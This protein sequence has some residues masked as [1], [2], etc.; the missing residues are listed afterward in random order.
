MKQTISVREMT[1]SGLLIILLILKHVAATGSESPMNISTSEP[2]GAANR[3]REVMQSFET[4]ASQ[5]AGVSTAGPQAQAETQSR[6]LVLAKARRA[7]LRELIVTDPE[8]ALSTSLPPRLRQGFPGEIENEMET[9]V[10]GTGDLFVVGVLQKKDGPIVPPI[11]RFVRINGK[12][13]QAY[14][15]GKLL[16]QKTTKNIPIHGIALDSLLALDGQSAGATA[17]S[18]PSVTPAK[19][20]VLILRVDFPD[21]PGDPGNG[22]YTASYVQNIMDSQIAPFFQRSSYGA[23]SLAYTV[24][25][26]VYRLPQTASFYATRDIGYELI[27]DAQCA[28]NSDFP[29]GNYDSFVVLFSSLSDLPGSYIT[30]GGASEIGGRNIWINGEFDFRVLVHELGHSY[31]LWHANLWQVTD[32]NPISSSGYGVEYADLFDAMSANLANDSR[33][34]YN[35]WFKSQVGWI[36]DDQIQVVSSSGTYRVHPFDRATA[37]GTLALKIAKDHLRNYWIGC[38]HNFTNNASMQNGA[39]IIWGYNVSQGSDLLDTTTPG[40]NVQD[41]A[42]AI[43]ATLFDP[44]IH[45][46]ISPIARGTAPDEYLDININ[47]GPPFPVISLGPQDQFV[48]PGQSAVF[49]VRAVGSP[50]PGCQWQCRPAGDPTWTNLADGAHYAGS[51]NSTLIIGNTSLAMN[52]DQLRCV[53]NNPSGGATSGPPA[54]LSVI[55]SGFTTVAGLA[56][57]PGSIDSIGSMARFGGPAGLAVDSRGNVF[58]A[59]VTKS[60]IR[61]ITSAGLVTTVAGFPGAAGSTDGSISDAR[62]SAPNSVV[63]DGQG[64]LY[65]ADTENQTIRRINRAGIVST[66]AGLA[67]ATGS[68]DG[69]GSDS[70]FCFPKGLA[71]DTA[72]NLYVTC[73]GSSTIRKITSQGD[74][75]TLAG[76]SGNPG[77][78]DGT[79]TSARFLCPNGIVVDLQNNLYVADQNNSTIRKI[80]RDGIVTTLAG[81]AG[82]TGSSDGIGSAARFNYPAGVAVDKA[83]NVYVADTG[84]SAIRKITA[85]GLVTTFAGLAG[86]V[87]AIEG[88]APNA[89]FNNPLGVAVDQAGNLYVAD[90]G[91]STVRKYAPLELD[92]PLL[93]ASQ[94]GS[95]AVLTWSSLWYGYSLE[96]RTNFAPGTSWLPVSE[97]NGNVDGMNFF[98]NTTGV[99]SIVFRLR[100]Q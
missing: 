100:R 32:G 23:A 65:V 3:P 26:R 49:A 82:I 60:T 31:G 16:A 36:R 70:R 33:A 34:D 22:L 94:L 89:R 92:P 46:T 30:Y 67:G 12:T 74:V 52:G 6:G 54:R 44:S 8:R 55:P 5:F 73:Q 63:A 83:G 61:K 15:Y 11:Q 42:L 35:P 29:L 25:P 28:V 7:V 17:P 68:A 51:T 66:V 59:D 58:V 75:S 72:G 78:V 86:H 20:R 97:P 9:S 96:S 98:T 76:L 99:P 91:N 84:N 69:R 56:E 71:I 88:P 62:F 41:A 93:Q 40:N 81:L 77:S 79:K 19:R 90:T 4:W 24:T 14:S 48:T 57:V 18:Q 87:G 45:L 64:N 80:T 10:S 21:L 37:S 50:E 13:Y 47:L 85:A 1:G 43:G 39:Y 53:I 27:A 38:R 2:D 95:S